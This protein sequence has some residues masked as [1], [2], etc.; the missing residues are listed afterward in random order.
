MQRFGGGGGAARSSAGIAAARHATQAHGQGGQERRLVADQCKTFALR[1]STSVY[2]A[3]P[4]VP[5]GVKHPAVH[6]DRRF[7]VL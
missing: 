3:P 1:L 7:G 4:P 5:P 6:R 2:T